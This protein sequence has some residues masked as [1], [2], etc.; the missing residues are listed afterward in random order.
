MAGKI[1]AVQFMHQSI[2]NAQKETNGK[3]TKPIIS[4][5]AKVDPSGTFLANRFY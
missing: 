3:E 1:H 2:L 5:S 4:N